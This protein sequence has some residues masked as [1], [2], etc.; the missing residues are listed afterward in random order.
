MIIFICFKYCILNLQNSSW[1][2]RNHFA[3]SLPLHNRTKR[4]AALEDWQ[5]W[6]C[7]AFVSPYPYDDLIIV[8][9]TLQ[10]F[11]PV[12]NGL[13]VRASA[14]SLMSLTATDCDGTIGVMFRTYR[15]LSVF[16]AFKGLYAMK[17]TAMLKICTGIRI[18]L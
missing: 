3:N 10:Y 5:C 7:R 18:L 14:A 16:I 4:T 13:L 17:V 15:R 2:Q 12:S 6:Q 9:S 8:H 11:Q 1:Q